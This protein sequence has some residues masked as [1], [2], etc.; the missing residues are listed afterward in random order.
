[1]PHGKKLNES[2]IK[3]IDNLRDKNYSM[4]EISKKN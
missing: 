1:M 4:T 3:I 2:E